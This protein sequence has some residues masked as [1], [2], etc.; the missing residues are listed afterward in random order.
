VTQQQAQ[1]LSFIRHQ[2]SIGEV[3]PSY[4]EMGD[5]MGIKSKSQVHQLIMALAEAGHIRHRA[6]RARSI[7]LPDR[8]ADAI[9]AIRDAMQSILATTSLHEAQK[10]AARVLKAM[11]GVAS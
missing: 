3:S 8:S 6:G 11:E 1:I 4:D 10:A 5:H 9:P 7:R 2:L